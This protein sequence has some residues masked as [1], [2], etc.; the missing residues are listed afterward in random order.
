MIGMFANKRLETLL[1]SR[2]IA[3]GSRNAGEIET[4]DVRGSGA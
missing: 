1:R 2:D 3:A 4:G